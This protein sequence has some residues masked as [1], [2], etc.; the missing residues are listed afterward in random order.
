MISMM[1]KMQDTVVNESKIDCVTQ[2]VTETLDV[3]IKSRSSKH[4]MD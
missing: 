1:W 3:V 2:N 4:D